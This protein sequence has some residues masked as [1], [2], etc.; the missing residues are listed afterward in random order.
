MCSA[1]HGNG[2]MI[3]SKAECKSH[4]ETLFAAVYVMNSIDGIHQYINGN[5]ALEPRNTKEAQQA[6]RVH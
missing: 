5:S 6:L 4:G 2:I 3:I 1:R